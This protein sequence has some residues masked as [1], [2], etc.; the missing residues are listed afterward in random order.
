MSTEKSKVKSPSPFDLVKSSI[1]IYSAMAF[2][3]FEIMW[4]FHKST[5][6]QFAIFGHDWIRD[7]RLTIV[8]IC[9]LIFG[10]LCLEEFFPSYR[11]LKITMSQLFK[12]LTRFQIFLVAAASSFGE[13]I[14][15]RGAIQ[16]YLGLW[17]TSLLFALVHIDPDGKT[18]IWTFWALIGGLIMGATAIATGSLWAPIMIH[19][20]VNL[21]SISR[22]VRLNTQASI[23]RQKEIAP[24]QNDD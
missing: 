11:G 18:W 7:I 15:F 16:P 10:N 19:F 4:W 22:V 6:Q 20:G 12:G 17:L 2:V 1:L 3:G 14:L 9:F 13:E 24:V 5:S 23:H 8:G 21:I